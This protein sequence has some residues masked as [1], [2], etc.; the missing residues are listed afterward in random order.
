MN[1]YEMKLIDNNGFN[2][3]SGKVESKNLTELKA[4]IAKFYPTYKI[5]KITLLSKK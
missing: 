2:G 3:V 4:K 5:D 1:L